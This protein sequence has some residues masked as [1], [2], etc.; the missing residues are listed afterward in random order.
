MIPSLKLYIF[1]IV[2]A[3]AQG[4]NGLTSLY[5]SHEEPPIDV[6]DYKSEIGFSVKEKWIEQ[7]LDHFNPLDAR[8]WK[9]RYL[10][11]E[12]FLQDG[13]KQQMRKE[14]V[15]ETFTCRWTNFCLHWR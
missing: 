15:K 3:Y 13:R 5:N 11:N 2:I 14:K 7:K 4:F 9:M 10:E 12:R 1:C 6:D 8:K